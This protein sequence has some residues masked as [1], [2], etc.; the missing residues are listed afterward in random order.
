MAGSK[1]QSRGGNEE[2]CYGSNGAAINMRGGKDERPEASAALVL[3]MLTGRMELS[4][5]LNSLCGTTESRRNKGR[6]RVV[7]LSE[8]YSSLKKCCGGSRGALLES[9][10]ERKQDDASLL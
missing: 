5:C 1:R 3:M 10:R 6:R 2:R 4:K 8:K 7:N 9:T